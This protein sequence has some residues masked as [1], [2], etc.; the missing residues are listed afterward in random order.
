MPDKEQ[1]VPEPEPKPD[2]PVNPDT[3]D[4]RLI[5]RVQEADEADARL[6]SWSQ[7]ARVE[8]ASE[9]SKDEG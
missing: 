2:D 7:K 8:R 3:S 6:I 1:Q 9:Q 4:P 5:S